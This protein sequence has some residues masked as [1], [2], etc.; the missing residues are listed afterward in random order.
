MNIYSTIQI[1]D[2]HTN[3]CEDA[4][5]IKNIGSDRLLIAV[6]D[7]CTTAMESHFA[8]TLVSKILRKIATELGYRELYEKSLDHLNADFELQEILKSLFKEL[9]SI[10]NQLLL[11]EKELLTTL[12]IVLYHKKE[13]QGIALAVGDGLVCINGELFNFN[14]DNKPDYL[15]FHLKEDF[16]SWYQNQTQKIFFNTIKDISIAT[17][18]I[19]TFSKM[20]S[21][22][23]KAQ[24]DPVDYLLM[25][26]MED[27]SDEMLNLR[28]K[29]LE[30]QYGLKPT[31]DIAIIRITNE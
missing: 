9:L 11:D 2:Y 15:G 14:Q 5:I 20:K 23:H 27:T 22:D 25:D 1:G 19:F 18:G 31:D 3:Q 29:K 12:I 24:I 26:K 10:K 7:G 28:M 6:M 16:D 17:D 13:K 21:T 30:N 4:L 8:S